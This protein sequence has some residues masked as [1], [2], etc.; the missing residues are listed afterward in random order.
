MI[1]GLADLPSVLQIL[2]S[3]PIPRTLWGH[4]P[5]FEMVDGL[6]SLRWNKGATHPVL[7]THAT[8][9]R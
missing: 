8:D 2:D 5:K 6:G 3:N 7:G 4:S 9:C 1:Q